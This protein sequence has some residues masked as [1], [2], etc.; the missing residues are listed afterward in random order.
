[1]RF[2]RNRPISPVARYSPLATRLTDGA[3]TSQARPSRSDA[4]DRAGVA[5]VRADRQVLA[6]HEVAVRPERP[7]PRRR[8]DDRPPEIQCSAVD[9]QPIACQGDRLAGQPDDPLQQQ[10]RAGAGQLPAPAQRRRVVGGRPVG[11]RSTSTRSRS[12]SSGCML[13][14]RTTTRRL[15]SSPSPGRQHARGQPDYPGDDIV[16]APAQTCP[17]VQVVADRSAPRVV[18][19]RPLLEY[20]FMVTPLVHGRWIDE[21]GRSDDRRHPASAAN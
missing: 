10:V 1:M 12:A 15:P 7:L 20:T 18:V 5:A 8:A 11:E 17:K 6:Q 13:T 21:S 9:V 14:P 19:S 16:A 3:Y 4:A 2:E